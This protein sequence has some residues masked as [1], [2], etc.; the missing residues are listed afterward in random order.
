MWGANNG[1]EISSCV[2][3]VCEYPRTSSHHQV[4]ESNQRVRLESE[5][6][7][8]HATKF[9]THNP[10]AHNP[11]KNTNKNNVNNAAN[12]VYARSAR[13][14]RI[15]VLDSASS[16]MPCWSVTETT[17]CSM[18]A[19]CQALFLSHVANTCSIPHS[20]HLTRV[21]PLSYA[22]QH[23]CSHLFSFTYSSFPLSHFLSIFLF[24]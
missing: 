9:G 18:N 2:G 15:R 22:Q 17:L 19:I 6:R 12:G 13:R 23:L 16:S 24:L 14:I 20:S 10:T 11:E 5:R 8:I 3:C 7:L 21:R 1:Q 4:S